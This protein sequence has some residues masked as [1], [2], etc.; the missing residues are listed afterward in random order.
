MV[1]NEASRVDVRR[2]GSLIASDKRAWRERRGEGERN[3]DEELGVID[4]DKASEAEAGEDVD[5]EEICASRSF[6][7][8]T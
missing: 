6:A 5:A 4:V 8:I 7:A 1:L 2:C 3:E